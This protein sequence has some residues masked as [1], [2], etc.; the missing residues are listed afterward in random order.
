MKH[1]AIP[2]GA[3]N[4][5]ANLLRGL[6]GS[7][8]SASW[9][10]KRQDALDPEAPHPA[11]RAARVTARLPQ[12]ADRASSKTK[13]GGAKGTD[14]STGMLTQAQVV[15]IFRL[16]RSDPDLWG[17]RELAEKCAVSEADLAA[18][19][20]YTRTY[21]AHTGADGAV[22]GYYDAHANPPIERFER[23]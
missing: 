7:I 16:R 5:W 14:T 9:D 6:S 22:R 21:T 12:P 19:L 11:R 18:L 4:E 2:A 3:D 15:G 20:R 1:S 10:G 13:T 8:G 17:A 23:D